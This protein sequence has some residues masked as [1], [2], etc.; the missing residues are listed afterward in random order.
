M[1][2][3][4]RI[5]KSKR[6]KYKSKLERFTAL[7]LSKSKVDYSYETEKISYVVPAKEKRYTPDFPIV[8]KG[9]RKKIYIECKGIWDAEDRYKHLLIKQQKPELDIRFVF[10]NSKTRISKNSKTTYADICEGRG[11]GPFKGVTWKYADKKIPREW[12]NE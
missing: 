6:A 1:P 5:T 8:T 12:I 4:K 2:S 10:G 11:R 9:T 7:S 3:G